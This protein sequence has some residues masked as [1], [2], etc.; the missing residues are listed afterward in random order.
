MSKLFVYSYNQNSESAR[1]LA[2]EL[3]IPR[4][5]HDNSRF[6][7]APD[8][9]VINWGSSS[10]SKEV[11]KCKVLNI[12]KAVGICSNKLTF[13]NVVKDVCSIPNFTDDKE[14]A[15]KWLDKGGIVFARLKLSGSGGEGIVEVGEAE[16]MPDAPLY[17]RY[18]PKQNEYRIHIMAG[19]VILVQ[20]KAL[21]SDMNSEG[22]NWHIRNQE[23][24]FIFARNETNHVVPDSVEIEAMRAFN[25]IK[26]LTFGSVDIIYNNHREKSYVLEINTAS[27]LA[28][29]T[30]G[31]YAN[32][33]KELLNN[34]KK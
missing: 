16:D 9:T 23:N 11:M 32:A 18:I 6:K 8:K 2:N 1:D 19:K 5:R 28:G 14:V 22:A 26:G 33:F 30:V 20:R 27:G 3:E 7:G 12:P 29:S 25:A 31:D 21:S 4:I 10:L 34:V 24:G 15:V 17:T 13:F